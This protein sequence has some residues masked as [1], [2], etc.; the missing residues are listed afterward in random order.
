MTDD[1]MMEFSEI[2]VRTFNIARISKAVWKN[3]GYACLTIAGADGEVA[4]AE[5]DH[6]VN[7]ARAMG[8]TE[9]IIDAWRKFDF[10]N[11][12]LEELIPTL[13]AD[14]PINASRSLLYSAIKM[15]S[16]D[17]DFAGAERAAV[18]RAAE[19]LGQT[20]HTAKALIHLVEMEKTLEDMRHALLESS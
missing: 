13:V 5:M 9:D 18:Y 20:A 14:S 7:H 4:P 12:S 19:I 3:Y 8:A 2:G 1:E 11:A 6:I 16:A 17:G 15:S 10:K